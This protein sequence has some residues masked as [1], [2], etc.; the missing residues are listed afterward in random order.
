M[1]SIVKELM[2]DTTILREASPAWLGRQRLD[3]YLPELNLALEY[4]G[5]Q[6][7]QSVSLF[8]GDEGLRKAIERDMLK[9]KLCDENG[10][11]LIYVNHTEPLNAPEMRQRLKKFINRMNS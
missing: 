11:Q 2:K 10:V 6:H 5:E 1:Y 7:F 4:Q 3:V 9:K 8:G